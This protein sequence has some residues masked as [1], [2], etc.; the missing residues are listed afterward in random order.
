[1]SEASTSVHRKPRKIRYGD[2]EWERIVAQARECNLPPAAF[3]REVSLGATSPAQHQV[4]F[5]L[6]RIAT[7]LQ[8]LHGRAAQAGDSSTQEELQL[9]LDQ[10][11][12]AIRR[13]GDDCQS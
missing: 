2:D 4:I 8:H 11:L 1:M 12:A 3:V 9:A 7:E 10:T 6:S 13:F 5:Q